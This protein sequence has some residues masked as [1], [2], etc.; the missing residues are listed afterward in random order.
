MRHHS[1]QRVTLSRP[2]CPVS[3]ASRAR[4][5]AFA[6]LL[7]ARQHRDEAPARAAAEAAA[8][9]EVARDEAAHMFTDVL[10]GRRAPDAAT[11]PTR[12]VETTDNKE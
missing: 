2:T 10:L 12:P 1:D 11:E 4:G 6:E 5:E 8:R 9:A 3:T 7:A